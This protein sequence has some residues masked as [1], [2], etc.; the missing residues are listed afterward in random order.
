M[1]NNTPHRMS[2]TSSIITL[3]L[4]LFV[5]C[6]CP[7]QDNSTSTLHNWRAG[8]VVSP[9]AVEAFG[10]ENAFAASEITD[11]IFG[12]IYGKSFKADCTT[13]HENLRYLRLLHYD[14]DGNI[15]LGELICH[16]SIATDLVEIFRELYKA[17]YPIEKMILIDEYNADDNASMRD[18]NSSAF[19]YRMK[20]AGKTLS[21][22]ALGLAID[23]NPLYNPYV[24][25]RSNGQQYIEPANAAPYADRSKHFHYKIDS[26]DICCKLFKQH[27]FKWGG[28]W[29]TIKDYQHFEK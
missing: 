25:T 22:H 27:G 28:D 3:L 11:D 8:T 24:K 5:A 12:R 6:C 1:Y 21:K 4:L 10:I 23:I 13:P 29:K 7:A 20:T 9:E 19:N 16:K 26:A 17:Q 14:I 18:N 2:R 15:R